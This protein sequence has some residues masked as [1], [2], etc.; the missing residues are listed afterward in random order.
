MLAIR[1]LLRNNVVRNVAQQ[2]RNMSVTCVPARTKVSKGEMIV[3]AS[4]MVIGWSV[5]PAWVLVN[6]KNYKHQE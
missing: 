2:Q 3:L 5:V 6:I 4:A 1:S